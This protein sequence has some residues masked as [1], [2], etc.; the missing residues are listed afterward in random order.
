MTGVKRRHGLYGIPTITIAHYDLTPTT[1]RK[2]QDT[3]GGKYERGESNKHIAMIRRS[4]L[5]G[6]TTSST[7]YHSL[8]P[9]KRKRQDMEGKSNHH[10]YTEYGRSQSELYAEKIQ[11]T[12]L[13][14][15]KK[16]STMTNTDVIKSGES[17]KSKSIP[18]G[19]RVY[20]TPSP[21]DTT[22]NYSCERRRHI[23]VEAYNKKIFPDKDQEIKIRLIESLIMCTILETINERD[24]YYEISDWCSK[25]IKEALN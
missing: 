18:K 19:E 16:F 6:V 8:T 12:N 14:V 9:T 20:L 24:R 11:S 1:K 22:V 13:S 25:K 10:T 4:G 17:V 15:L 3:D 23:R 21:S 7:T 2:W 5:Y